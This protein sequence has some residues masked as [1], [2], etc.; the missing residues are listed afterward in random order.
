MILDD[1]NYI[2]VAKIDY[3]ES[4][5]IRK[6]WAPAGLCHMAGPAPGYALYA[7]HPGY[8]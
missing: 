3:L 2:Y 8:L 4:G 5:E 7:P 6:I 1:F